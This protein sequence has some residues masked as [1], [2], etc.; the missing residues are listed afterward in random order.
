MK[1]LILIYFSCVKKLA[2]QAPIPENGQTHT[3]NLSTVAGKGLMLVDYI[4]T[5]Y[6][7]KILLTHFISIHFPMIS[8]HMTLLFFYFIQKKSIIIYEY[9]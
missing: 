2:L 7:I 5:G 9:L 8:F 6:C 3:N 4:T 1:S